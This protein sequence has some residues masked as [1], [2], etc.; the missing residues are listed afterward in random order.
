MCTSGKKYFVNNDL[1]FPVTPYTSRDYRT[2]YGPVFASAFVFYDDSNASYNRAVRRHFASRNPDILEYDLMMETRQLFFVVNHLTSIKSAFLK[3]FNSFVIPGRAIDLCVLLVKQPHDKR[4]LRELAILFLDNLGIRGHSLWSRGYCQHKVKRMD[5]CKITKYPRTI[6]DLGTPASLA[7]GYI[8]QIA[9]EHIHGS[10]IYNNSEAVFIDKPDH[11]ELLK[12]FNYLVLHDRNVFLM[13]FSDDCVASFKRGGKYYLF[14]LDLK[15]CDASQGMGIF[16][17]MFELF[18]FP[19]EVQILITRQVMQPIL[20]RGQEARATFKPLRPHLQSGSTWT[21]LLNNCSWYLLLVAFEGVQDPTINDIVQA[22]MTVG[23]DIE[24]QECS[25]ISDVQFLKH[26][27][28][29]ETD[30]TLN[31]CINIGVV[32]RASGNCKRDLP[33]RG[34][35]KIRSKCM[36]TQ[37]MQ[38]IYSVYNLDL[39][40]L[41]SPEVHCRIL[42]SSNTLTDILRKIVKRP[43]P[44]NV[45]HAVYQRYRLSQHQLDELYSYVQYA[46][47]HDSGFGQVIRCTAAS[48]ILEKDYG[49]GLKPF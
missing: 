32:L 12:W 1:T 15:T 46:S 9:K 37:V 38:G 36:Q 33:G 22:G 49:I 16:K 6:V 39:F 23:Y 29:Y 31:E 28:Y 4:K 41:L 30:G 17:L 8:C 2:C 43:T 11:D 10:Y 24:V 18:D 21:T 45:T 47:Q 26:S 27:P 25:H 44:V 42:D 5:S 3:S 34:D 7:V 40:K 19:K 48:I 14:N 35:F 20:I 13:Y